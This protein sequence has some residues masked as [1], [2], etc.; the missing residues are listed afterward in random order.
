MPSTPPPNRRELAALPTCLPTN[1]TLPNRP[2]T[3]G[4]LLWADCPTARAGV[5]SASTATTAPTADNVIFLTRPSFGGRGHPLR[6][7]RVVAGSLPPFPPTPRTPTK[8]R[9]SGAPAG[10]GQIGQTSTGPDAVS[11]PGPGPTPRG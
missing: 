4:L 9:D 6:A 8:R 5:L 2:C 1:G 11:A 3:T 10:L 7:E